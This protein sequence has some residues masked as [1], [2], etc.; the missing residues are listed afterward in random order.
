MNQ[1][2]DLISSIYSTALNVQNFDRLI[3]LSEQ[4]LSGGTAYDA[5]LQALRRECEKHVIEAEK[6]LDQ[7][8][9]AP[10]E[11]LQKPVFFVT[12]NGKFEDPNEIAQNLL[13]ITH[14]DELAARLDRDAL[15]NGHNNIPSDADRHVA[16]IR[17]RQD[18]S[19][20]PVILIPDAPA[21]D[22]RVRYV[23]LDAIWHGTA[24]KAVQALYGLTPSEA[25]VLGLL[26]SGYAP[27]E[28]A[29]ARDR[30]VET[31]R[32]QIK[33][34]TQK[35]H[36]KGLQEAIHLARAVA[37]SCQP[38]QTAPEL[39]RR[40]SLILQDGRTLDFHEQGSPTGHPIIFLHGCLGGNRLPQGADQAFKAAGIRLIA[41]ARPW[42]GQSS[43]HPAL[44]ND[45]G[46]Y[47]KDLLAL[48]DHLGVG[49]FSLLTYDTGSIFALTGA[50]A[51][52]DRLVSIVCTA[53][54]PPMRSF[55]DFASAPQ[56]HRIFAILARTSVPVLRY[57][58]LL[59]DRKLKKEGRDRFPKTIFTG[60]EADLAACRDDEVLDLMWTGHHFHVENGSDSFINDCRFIASNWSENLE[61]PACPV[62][63]LH[64]TKDVSIHPDRIRSLAEKLGAQTTWVEGAGHALPFSHWKPVVDALTEDLSSRQNPCR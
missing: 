15:E 45:P 36:A 19:G 25:E 29:D 62:H 56:Q 57:L 9:T 16:A 30:S 49:Q 63:F 37:V 2:S 22:G 13:G 48:A 24:E 23:G 51:L 38:A 34:I 4:T 5:E 20:K 61:R 32:Q 14:G 54:Q 31:V 60:S 58:S 17:L 27:T 53:A 47:A 26:M 8:P 11:D 21:P 18:D 41:P 6:L 64:G 55:S 10:D 12:P 28:V 35:L 7:L 39:D 52:S 50:P 43:G 1:Y 44:L 46:L 40:R 33:A 59:G 3:T 42:H